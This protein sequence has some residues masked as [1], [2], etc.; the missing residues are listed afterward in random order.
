LVF[1]IVIFPSNY[2]ESS[3]L[4]LLEHLRENFSQLKLASIGLIIRGWQGINLLRYN[5]IMGDEQTERFSFNKMELKILMVD[6]EERSLKDE[7]ESLVQKARQLGLEL[8]ASRL[9]NAYNSIRYHASNPDQETR[10]QT[11]QRFNKIASELK[12]KI[13]EEQR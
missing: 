10:K 11:I 12:E 3:S 7:H 5:F 2:I 8:E 13:E 4:L 1:L 9:T 6:S